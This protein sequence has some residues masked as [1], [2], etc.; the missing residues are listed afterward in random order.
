MT[1]RP[2]D[3]VDQSGRLWRW[4]PGFGCYRHDDDKYTTLRTATEISEGDDAEPAPEPG[5]TGSTPQVSA[6]P[7]SATLA[8]GKWLGAD[9]PDL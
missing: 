2:A 8:D 1:E 7:P 5:N 9:R 4:D 3:H 6:Q